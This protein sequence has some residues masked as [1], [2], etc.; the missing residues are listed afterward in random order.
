MSLPPTLELE[1]FLLELNQYAQTH[2]GNVSADLGQQL[3]EYANQVRPSFRRFTSPFSFLSSSHAGCSVLLSRFCPVQ[4]RVVVY[5]VR[6]APAH[7][8]TPSSGGTSPVKE[9]RP[10]SETRTSLNAHRLRL[11]RA[12]HA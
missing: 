5:V 8:S 6:G 3:R 12:L 10:H 4:S 7:P 2:D 1:D 9:T 11:L